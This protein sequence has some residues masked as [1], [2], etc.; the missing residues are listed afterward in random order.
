LTTRTVRGKSK[1]PAYVFAPP[2][3]TVLR[4]PLQV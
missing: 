1:N 3:A 4:R 2:I